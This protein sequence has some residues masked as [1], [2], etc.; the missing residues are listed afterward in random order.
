MRTLASW[1][2]AGAHSAIAAHILWSQYSGSPAE[3]VRCFRKQTACRD[4]ASRCVGMPQIA[5]KP[6]QPLPHVP[7]RRCGTSEKISKANNRIV[8]GSAKTDLINVPGSSQ[9]T[10]SALRTAL[11]MPE[12]EGIYSL[13]YVNPSYK[14]TPPRLE[15]HVAPASSIS[16]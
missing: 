4:C 13:T 9:T 2:R 12:P 14:C 8:N 3:C 6:P 5:R 7:L 15:W 10:S 11:R 16:R 1:D